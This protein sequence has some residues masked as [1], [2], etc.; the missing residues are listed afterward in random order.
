MNLKDVCVISPYRPQLKLIQASPDVEV[1]TVD[2]FQGRDKSCV[3]L[4]MVRS[5]HSQSVRR[6]FLAF[7]ACLHIAWR[8]TERLEAH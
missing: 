2:Q 4:S 1:S 3:I 6:F 5:N 8:I 7:N